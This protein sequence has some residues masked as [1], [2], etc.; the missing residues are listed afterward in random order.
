VRNFLQLLKDRHTVSD[1]TVGTFEDMFVARAGTMS[2]NMAAVADRLP[3]Q[4]RRGLFS[5][6]LPIRPGIDQRYRDSYAA[7]IR[8]VGE[9]YKSGITIVAGTDGW[10]G[11]GLHRELEL[12][13]RAGIPAPEVLRIATLGAARVMKH[14]DERGSIAPGKL[15]DVILVDGDPSTNIS[16]IRKVTTVVRNGVVYRCADLYRSLGIKP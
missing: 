16:D 4:V 6:G 10:P 14:D 8:M 2:P 5:G 12:Y 1:P 7:M 9:L 15:A 3:S 11:F 13:V